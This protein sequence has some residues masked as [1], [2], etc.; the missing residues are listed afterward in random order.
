M[1]NDS[2]KSVEYPVKGDLRKMMS[3]NPIPTIIP[4]TVDPA[5]MGDGEPTKEAR[6]VL[7]TLNAALVANDAQKLEGCFY[8]GQAYWKDLLALTYHTRTFSTPGVIAASLME[9][10]SLRE[11][12]EGF[13]LQGDAL[14]I[15]ATPVLVRPIL[16]SLYPPHF[17]VLPDRSCH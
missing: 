14:F 17:L 13:E 4:G 10:A 9:T 15:P 5:S 3:W 6:A 7:Q 1:H 8:P 11:L 2:G 12:K 16:A